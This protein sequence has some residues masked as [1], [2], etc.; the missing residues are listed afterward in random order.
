[1][2]NQFDQRRVDGLV[3]DV[4][5]G[6]VG[7]YLGYGELPAD[8]CVVRDGLDDGPCAG[9]ARQ[10][11]HGGVPAGHAQFIAVD[12]R[13]LIGYASVVHQVGGPGI[14]AVRHG[15]RPLAELVFQTSRVAEHA[16]VF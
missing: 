13:E 4:T 6:L 1:M 9:D 2:R 8:P 12:L 10:E 7:H 15:Q 3:D 5:E 14:S 16:E 11:Q